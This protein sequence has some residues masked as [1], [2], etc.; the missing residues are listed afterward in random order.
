MDLLDFLSAEM[1]IGHRL[2]GR[3]DV[4]CRSGMTWS[5]DFIDNMR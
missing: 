3:V 1:E 5:S 4:H 2:A